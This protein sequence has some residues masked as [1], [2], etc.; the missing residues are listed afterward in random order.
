MINLLPDDYKKQLRAARANVTIARYT[1]V[2]VL[3]FG[4]LVLV[5]F[6]SYLLLSQTKASADLLIES[7]STDASE[8][9]DTQQ[10]ITALS[11]NLAGAQ[12]LLDA[13]TSYATVFRSI[14]EQKP[15]GTIIQSIELTPETFGGAPV[16]LQVYATSTEETVRLRENLQSSPMFA[17]INVASIS[18]NDGIDGYPIGASLTMVINRTNSL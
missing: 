1:G 12:T 7:N 16:T 6:G 8:F 4:F 9:A 13:Q 3:A 10:Q 14:G 17:N 15:D 2:I 5:L 11:A 18:E